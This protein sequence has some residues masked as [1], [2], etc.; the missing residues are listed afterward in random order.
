MIFIIIS[1]VPYKNTIIHKDIIQAIKV[2][3]N[4]T[5]YDSPLIYLL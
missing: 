3:Q 5:F 2:D 4:Y 1:S